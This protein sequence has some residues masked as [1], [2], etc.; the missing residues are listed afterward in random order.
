MKLYEQKDANYLKLVEDFTDRD[1][2]VIKS[3][4]L[5]ISQNLDLRYDK[6][7]YLLHYIDIYYSDLY[8]D[9]LFNEYFLYLKNLCLMIEED[10]YALESYLSEKIN[11]KC[12]AVLSPIFKPRNYQDLYQKKIELPRFQNLEEDSKEIKDDLKKL[13]TDFNR[14]TIYSEEELKT[15]IKS[16]KEYVLA[17]INVI[18]KLDEKIYQYKVEKNAFEFGDIAKM[19]I[20]LVKNH[21]DIR[22]ELKNSYQEI[23]ID[24]YQDTNDLQEMFIKEI[25]NN[26]VY[27][28]GDI[29]Q[30]IY[31]FRNANPNIFKE[32][33][34]KYKNK[35]DGEKIDLL[36]NFRSRKEVLKAINDIFALIMIPEVGGVDYQ[37]HHAM[38]FGN[39]A[40]EDAGKNM[41][42][43][44]LEI[45][46][47]HKIDS[48][49]NTEIE[50][51]T[52]AQ[53]IKK[54]VLEHLQ[55]YDFDLGKNRDIQYKDFCIILDRGK[56]MGRYKKIFEYFNIP[57]QI[58]QDSNLVEQEDILIIRNILRLILAIYH[59][60]YDSNMRYYFMSVARSFIGNM[61]DEEIFKILED[62]TFYETEIYKKAYELS[63]KIDELSPNMLLKEIILTFQF[64][65]KL[66]F[67]NINA[68]EHKFADK[69]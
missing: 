62:N 23:M 4:I 33:Y 37:D 60:E 64:Y 55:V 63:K 14:L 24:E 20:S 1:D 42:N 36:E 18:L 29:K 10:Y 59:K 32:K 11:E 6:K 19:A 67:C 44:D 50:A 12:Y 22:E 8:I 57:M 25:Q 52:I 17:I 26:N 38:I 69:C 34:E 30:S 66:I 58:Y 61:R 9:Q 41:E 43:H 28:V 56:E 40:Y 48:Y 45:L 7:S 65:E 35:I 47:Y 68:T 3:A 46:K 39:M 16:T 53:D 15:Q 54:K 2:D 51:F 49:S 5:D 21:E 13:I 27:M 31:R